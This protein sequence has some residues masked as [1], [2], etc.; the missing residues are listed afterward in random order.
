MKITKIEE[1][2]KLKEGFANNDVHYADLPK[3]VLMNLLDKAVQ[4]IDDLENIQMLGN[5][6]DERDWKDQWYD[7]KY[8]VAQLFDEIILDKEAEEF[9]KEKYNDTTRISE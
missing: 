5:E 9:I 4:R 3:D 1:I 8:I 2:E 6:D 7:Q